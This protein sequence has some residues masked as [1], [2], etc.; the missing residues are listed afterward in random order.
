MQITKRQSSQRQQFVA[1]LV[2][3]RVALRSSHGASKRSQE[4]MEEQECQRCDNQSRTT[5][6]HGGG[7]RKSQLPGLFWAL[8]RGGLLL[9]VTGM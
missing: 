7:G 2:A 6:G 8:R 1:P 9:S 3:L 4:A 5:E